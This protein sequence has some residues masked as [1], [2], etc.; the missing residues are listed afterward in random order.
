MKCAKSVF[1]VLGFALLSPAPFP[2]LIPALIPA[3]HAQNQLWITQFGTGDPREARDLAP[4]DA[5]VSADAGPH[6]LALPGG[7]VFHESA[8]PIVN[9]RTVRV[10]GSATVLVLW[11]EV[12]GDLAVPHYAI[13]FDGRTLAGRVRETS[14]AIGLRQEFDPLQEVPAVHPALL[15]GAGNT[16]YLVQFWT[17]PLEEF[18]TQIERRGGEVVRFMPSPT[19]IVRLG[20]DVGGSAAMADIIAKFGEIADNPTFMVTQQFA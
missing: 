5:I 20:A 4:R 6:R 16:L 17:V 11:D 14:Y 13:S 1:V 10:P 3:A 15:A 7:E 18:R 9:V 2:H 19:H 8:D 12:R